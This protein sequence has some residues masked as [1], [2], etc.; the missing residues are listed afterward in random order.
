M[1]VFRIPDN[2]PLDVG[3][4]LLCAGITVYN[5]MVYYGM[6]QP[7]KHLGVAGLGGLGHVAVKISKAF[8]LKV[9]VIS[10]SPKKESE[11]ID[12]LGVDSFLVSIDPAKFKATIGTMD[13]IIDT[14]AAAHA[15]A[16]LLSLLNVNRKLVTV[17]LPEKP[18]ELPIFPLVI[19]QRIIGGSNVGGIK[20]TQEMLDFCSKHNITADIELIRID[21]LN[22]AMERL[23]KSDVKYWFVIDVGNSLS[24]KKDYK[25][26]GLH[27]EKIDA[28]DNDCIIYYKEY[29]E[30]LE[31][32][33]CGLPR[34]QPKGK[35]GKGKN[36]PWKVLRYFPITSRL[37]RLFMSSKTAASMRW[38]FENRVKD[39]LLRHPADS[40]AWKKFD[41]KH[42]TFTEDP[43]NVRLGLA[44]D[45][46]NPFGNMNVAHSTWPVLL[47]PYNLPP[48]MCMKEPYTFMSLLIPSP[49]GP[50]NDIDVYLRPLIDELNE[51]WENGVNTYDISTQQNFQMKAAIMW[52]VND[53]PAYAYMSGWITKGR[54]ACPCCAKKT[55]HFSLAN[56]S[57]ICYM[58]HR[59]FLPNDHVWRNQ[60]SQFNGKKE[61]GDAP[62]RPASDE[63]FTE[64]QGLTPITY[65]TILENT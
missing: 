7:G 5:P 2:M 13:Y 38:H 3:A 40:E 36:V 8:G 6:N 45:G 53:F 54:L 16:P 15:L 58:G 9:T 10:T 24:N 56:G 42:E 20:E 47:F 12:I 23:A 18:L 64:L 41:E 43:R 26:L 50:G 61:T 65:A 27:Y 17:G 49:K 57:K 14:I 59:R 44:T 63:V 11:V 33:V 35:S 34:W 19:G 39:G 4:P 32:P 37:Q 46:F 51:L 21:E 60:M 48:W 1:W 52:T 29:G 62:K 55:D 30:A 25:D 22:E 31:C 28:C